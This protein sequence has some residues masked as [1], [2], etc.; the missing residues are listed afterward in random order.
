M[1]SWK[2]T[3]LIVNTVLN[4]GTIVICC[5]LLFVIIGLPIVMIYEAKNGEDD[6]DTR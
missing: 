6:Y 2:V 4:V 1:N 3:D 5:S